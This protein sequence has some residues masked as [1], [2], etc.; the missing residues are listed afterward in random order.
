MRCFV[1]VALLVGMASTAD[2]NGRPP[3]TNGVVI[4]PGDSTELFVR[5]TFGLLISKDGGC[6]FRWV[7]EDAI[8]YGGTYDPKYAIAGD[9]TIYA[10]TFEG[11]RLSRDNGCTWTTAA[12]PVNDTWID[13]LDIAPNGDV[14]VATAESGARNDIFRSTDG[15]Q[16]FGARGMQSSEI[17]WKS[18]KVAKT[19]PQFVY[20]AGYQVSG[21]TQ[22]DASPPPP[23][24]H[25]LRTENGGETWAESGLANVEFAAT[26]IVLVAAIDPVTPTTVLMISIGAN[27][28]SGDKLYRSTDGGESWTEVLA[29]ENTIRDVVFHDG[30]VY[31]ATLSG[32]FESVDGINYVPLAG[33]PQLG[34]LGERDGSLV[35]CGANWQPDFKAVALQ[36]DDD[37]WSKIFRFVELAG[38]LECDAGTTV[39]ELCNPL[40][41]AL[42]MQF[43]ATGPTDPACA[44]PVLDGPDVVGAEPPPVKESGGCCEAGGGAPFGAM[45]LAALVAMF[46]VRR[47]KHSSR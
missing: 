1:V 47:R 35:G 15:G 34:C 11:L 6:S 3:A 43:G 20:V 28:P 30:S 9:G 23:S 38:P 37:S 21:P 33:A 46:G 44:A 16:T 7:C 5:T 25:F 17:W 18:V 39:A 27:R 14:W 41:P 29:T 10:T 42:Q 8:G 19:S 32:S 2:A 4:K 45:G 26:P 22:P 40:W 31:V 12:A 36:G 13:A 24:A